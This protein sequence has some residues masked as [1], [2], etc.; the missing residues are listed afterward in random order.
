MQTTAKT[1]LRHLL[2]ADE[3]WLGLALLHRERREK[4]SFTAREIL[5]RIKAERAS[6]EMR[7]GLQPH[8]YLQTLPTWSRIQPDTGCSI[9]CQMTHT[10]CSA[11]EIQLIRH[12]REK[13]FRQERNSRKNT[14]IFWIGMN[15]TI[16]P[17]T[18]R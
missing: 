11:P 1:G 10:G 15:T 18:R 2:V 3:V 8:V 4:G 13:W 9:S 7:P 17:R 14:N 12:A 5:D 16:A 6:P